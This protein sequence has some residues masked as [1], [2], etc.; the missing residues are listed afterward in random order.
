[1]RMAVR[2]ARLEKPRKTGG[3]LSAKRIT[4]VLMLD[5]QFIREHPEVVKESQRKRGESV[6]LVD[7]DHVLLLVTYAD[8]G[9]ELEELSSKVY[10]VYCHWCRDYN[11]NAENVKNFKTA[12]EK[13]FTYV[14]QR[15]KGGGEKTT[16]ILGCKVRD[17]ELGTETPDVAAFTSL[18]DEN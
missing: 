17:E 6:E 9:P 1:M 14:R 8:E 12:M 4:L 3:D 11:Y 2:C 5:I 13:R 16:L 7:E 18:P 15:P 10:S